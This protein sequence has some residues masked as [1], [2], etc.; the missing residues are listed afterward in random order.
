MS[1]VL[2]KIILTTSINFEWNSFYW[3]DNF[4]MEVHERKYFQHEVEFLFN[5]HTLSLW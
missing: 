4:S 1:T 3:K 2:N 5:V